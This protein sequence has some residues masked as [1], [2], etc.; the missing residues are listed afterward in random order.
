VKHSLWKSL[1][2]AAYRLRRKQNGAHG[3]PSELDVIERYIAEMR[4]QPQNGPDWTMNVHVERFVY[5]LRGELDR[6]VKAEIEMP[7]LRHVGTGRL[8]RSDG[9]ETMAAVILSNAC[10]MD[11]VTC[12]VGTPE[13]DEKGRPWHWKGRS[14]TFHEDVT[15]RSYEACKYAMQ[16]IYER[17]GM[18]RFPQWEADADHE[19]HNRASIRHF[20]P[21]FFR[22][23]TDKVWK[24][25]QVAR[26]ALCKAANE[27]KEKVVETAEALGRMGARA[28]DIARNKAERT[29]RKLQGLNRRSKECDDLVADFLAKHRVPG[30]RPKAAPT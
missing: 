21:D 16:G 15:G 30:M 25:L 17:G 19:I 2:R 3:P 26:E 5:I 18:T 8:V 14:I 9:R 13:L 20:S 24:G 11:Y 29:A 7:S 22:G 28:A 6:W 4:K 12:N 1:K 27:V 10:A 23:L